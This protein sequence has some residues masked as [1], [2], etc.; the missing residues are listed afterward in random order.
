MLAEDSNV[1][2]HR[3]K[4]MDIPGTILGIKH[5]DVACNL[6]LKDTERQVCNSRRLAQGYAYYPCTERLW[7]CK[8]HI[9]KINNNISCEAY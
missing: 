1:T 6:S 4:E 3:R 7:F 8:P 5:T 9:F 2:R